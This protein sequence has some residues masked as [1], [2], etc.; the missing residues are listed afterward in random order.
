[1]NY[2]LSQ[3]RSGNTFLRYCIEF[4]TN[5]ATKGCFGTQELGLYE[6]IDGIN[7]YKNSKCI[8]Q[9]EHST[10][11]IKLEKDNKI[12]KTYIS[13]YESINNWY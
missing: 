13:K 8:L 11:N 3:P 2:L 1:M 4:I 6:K 7:I 5:K 10:S 9:K 12:Y